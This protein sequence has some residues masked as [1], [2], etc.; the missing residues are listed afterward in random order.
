[1]KSIL[2]LPV[3][4]LWLVFAFVAFRKS[5]DG[6]ATGHPDLGLWWG[7]IAALLTIAGL[8]ALVGGYLHARYHSR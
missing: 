6:L 4:L 2:G 3:F 1:M 7:V 8:G 5:S